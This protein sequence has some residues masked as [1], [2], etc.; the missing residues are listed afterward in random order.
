MN[1]ICPVD[2]TPLQPAASN[3]K[4]AY[5]KRCQGCWVDG[6]ALSSMVSGSHADAAER[7]RLFDERV[8]LCKPADRTCP[9][10]PDTMSRF[11]YRAID[12]DICPRCKGVWF[13]SGELKR[14]IAPTAGRAAAAGA[15]VAAL[16]GTALAGEDSEASKDNSSSGDSVVEGVVDVAVAVISVLDLF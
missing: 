4:I 13:D 8:A 2:G 10:H 9:E 6:K 12:L 7:K 3:G 1:A 16:A 15:A 5:C 11:V 14:L